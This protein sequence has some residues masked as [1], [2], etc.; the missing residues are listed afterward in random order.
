MPSLISAVIMTNVVPCITIDI[1]L[2]FT[3]LRVGVLP[4][5]SQQN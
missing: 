4:S 2:I 5:R 3:T 1:V